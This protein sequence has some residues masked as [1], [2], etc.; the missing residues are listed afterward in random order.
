MSG[1]IEQLKSNLKDM[2]E[3]SGSILENILK[4]FAKAICGP[5]FLIMDIINGLT[6]SFK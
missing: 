4:E 1:E 6:S 3:N 2:K 5:F